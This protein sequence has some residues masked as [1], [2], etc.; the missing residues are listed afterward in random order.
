MDAETEIFQFQCYHHS[1]LVVNGTAEKTQQGDQ[2][3][4]SR[5]W[6]LEEGGVEM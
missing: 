5:L 1:Y 2:K 3:R 4:I 6:A